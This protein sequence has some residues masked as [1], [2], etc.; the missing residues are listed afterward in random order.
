MSR[1]TAPEAPVQ[2]QAPEPQ[3][4]VT[5][6]PQVSVQAPEPQAPVQAPEPD[7]N[8]DAEAKAKEA[9]EK[10]EAEAKLALLLSDFKTKAHAV[11]AQ[12]NATGQLKI[13]VNTPE[14]VTES[15]QSAGSLYPEFESALA[16]YMALPGAAAKGKAKDFMGD[17]MKDWILKSADDASVMPK[18]IAWSVLQ[19]AILERASKKA[20]TAG[21]AL[22][23]VDSFLAKL[24]TVRVAN[25]LV[26]N[27]QPDDL[28]SNWKQNLDEMVQVG[29]REAKLLNEWQDLPEDQREGEEPKLSPYTAH[30][31]KLASGKGPRKPGRPVGA[32]STYSGIRRDIAKHIEHAFSDK[33]SGTWLSINE[34]RSINSPEYGEVSPSGG[35]ISARL[36]PKSG[37]NTVDGIVA[38]LDSNGRKGA[39]KL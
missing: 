7:A 2:A 12:H 4:P 34:I 37:K 38:E 9:K 18:V 23:P 28:P 1:Q 24:A 31:V 20:G 3:A 39:R 29:L 8:A 25:Q 36:Y 5:P 13:E 16:A 6:E 27:D 30:A 21:P 17:Q 15:G 22:S 32:T 33:P 35:A 26:A 14:E 11:I 10:K 19:T